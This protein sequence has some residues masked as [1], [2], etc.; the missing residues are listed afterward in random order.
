[1]QNFA[2]FHKLASRAACLATRSLAT[3][4]DKVVTQGP[5]GSRPL[6]CAP[7]ATAQGREAYFT[8]AME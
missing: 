4:E 1:M 3:R 7:S 2:V 6:D 5:V 8:L